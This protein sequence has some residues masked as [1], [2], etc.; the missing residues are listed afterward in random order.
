MKQ[1]RCV[2]CGKLF[3]TRRSKVECG[4]CALL[5]AQGRGGDTE[6]LP[7]LNEFGPKPKADL[8]KLLNASMLSE[9]VTYTIK[10]VEV[11]NLK[12]EAKP[13]ASFEEVPVQW[14]INKTNIAALVKKLGNVELSQL[15]GHKVTLASMSTTF[16]GAQTEGIR[17]VTVA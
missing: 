17:I 14:V 9:P 10:G 3:R 15:A 1:R 8:P 7:S 11:R 4:S 6:K 16:Q 2:R 13:I 5:I 12:G